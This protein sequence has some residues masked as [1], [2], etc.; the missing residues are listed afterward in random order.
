[1]AEGELLV[2]SGGRLFLPPVEEGIVWTTERKGMP[3]KLT[4]RIP[5]E[6]SEI[7]EG[8]AVRFTW[9]NKPVFYGFVFTKKRSK[10]GF[11]DITAYDQL[12]YLKN[13]DT[14]VYT[15]KTA[16]EVLRMIAEDFRL[17]CGILESTGYRIPSAVEDNQTLFDIIQNALDETLVSTRQIYCL[18]DD[19]GKLTLRNVESMK[20]D[21]LLDNVSAQDYSYSSSIDKQTYNKIKLSRH[22]EEAGTREIYIA[23]HGENINRW[24]TL[25]YFESISSEKTD[26]TSKANTLLGLYN[27]KTRTLKMTNV[28]GDVRARAGT[29]PIIH[30]DLGDKIVQNYMIIEKA[31]HTF[32]AGIYMMDLTLRGREFIV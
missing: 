19:F 4:F 23:Q 12:R 13:K 16:S 30:L 8:A 17:Q 28:F 26:G 15:D 22:N 7:E 9:K 2:E 21:L 1:M 14:Y 29:A 18:Y 25:Q 11:T 20:L 10:D 6:Q 3:G 31:A 24:G 27:R 32:G 5:A